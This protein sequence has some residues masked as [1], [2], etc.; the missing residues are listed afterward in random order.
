ML[1]LA[2]RYCNFWTRFCR[3]CKNGRPQTSNISLHHALC[4]LRFCC[5]ALEVS[6]LCSL[7]S[8]LS[9]VVVLYIEVNDF[10]FKNSCQNWVMSSLSTWQ[11]LTDDGN[12][13]N[14]HRIELERLGVDEGHRVIDRT[15]F[16]FFNIFYAKTSKPIFWK[17]KIFET[18]WTAITV[19]ADFPFGNVYWLTSASTLL[20]CVVGLNAELK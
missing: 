10:H 18:E 2:S 9:G 16:V 5:L 20:N 15:F 4:L 3:I 8:F 19:Q 1:S 17:W 12:S 6:E 7:F 11:Q 14:S 13:H